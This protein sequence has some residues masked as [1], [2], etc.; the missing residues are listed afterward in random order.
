L[1][2]WD[3]I[4][5][6]YHGSPNK[7]LILRKGSSITQDRNLARAFS[8]NPKHVSISVR[9]NISDDGSRRVS[10][11]I[12]HD[13]KV[14][15]YLYRI[16]ESVGPEDICPNPNS[17]LEPGEELLTKRDLK[18]ELLSPTKIV[19]EERLTEEVISE[20]EQNREKSATVKEG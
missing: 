6:W 9:I 15:G 13:G 17:S 18:V 8:H 7:F 19:D 5:P 3:Y 11:K 2:K 12:K 14:A 16:A 20:L 10:R 4:G 1:D